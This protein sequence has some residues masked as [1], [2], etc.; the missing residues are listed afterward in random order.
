MCGSHLLVQSEQVVGPE[1]APEAG[2][3]KRGD[4][5]EDGPS[6]D[7]GRL[8]GAETHGGGGGGSTAIGRRRQQ[9]ARL[10]GG[11]EHEQRRLGR[12][13]RGEDGLDGRADERR[14]GQPQGAEQGRV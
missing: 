10:A 14:R 3:E 12:E 9:V 5:G 7:A 1:Q 6:V 2:P 13:R 11:L 4:P 8:L